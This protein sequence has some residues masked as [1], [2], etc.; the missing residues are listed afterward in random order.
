MS[1]NILF[2]SLITIWLSAGSMHMKE[3]IDLIVTD[4]TIYTVDA[5]NSKVGSMAVHH[6]KIMAVGTSESIS[7]RYQA[8]RVVD[9]KGK[10][11]YPGFVDA[12][13]HFVGYA[14]GLQY[15]D[16]FGCQ[17]FDEI[18][19]RLKKA[20]PQSSG[21]LV[22][23][24]WDQ[25]L[26]PEKN[27]PDNHR[28]NLL[29]PDIPV[30]L[31]RVDGHVVLTNQEALKRAGIGLT[32]DFNSI[33][34]ESKN[35]RLTGILSETAADRMRET[36]PAP[37][38][39]ELIDLLKIAEKQCFTVGLT[40]VS[41]AGLDY[42]QVRVIDSLQKAGALNMNVYAMLTPNAENLIKFVTKGPYQTDRLTVRSIK[43]YSDGSLG[44]RTAKLKQPYSD[45][46]SGTG[47][48]VIPPDSIRELCKM[49]YDH[50]FQVNTHCI[51]DSANKL[52][53]DI[54]G[55]FLKGKNDLR[56]RIEHAQVV[57]PEDIHFFGD[58]SVIPSVQA[59]H[60]TSDMKWA[61]ERLGP[62]RIH[63]AYAYKDLMKQ[64]GW[65]ANGT[66][67]PIENISPLLT[68]YAAVARQDVNG[69]PE[70][71]YMMNNALSRED[72]LRSIT[73]WAVKADFMEQSKGSLEAGKD[74]DFV[75]LDQ[76]I[77]HI[78]IG[79]VPEVLVLQTF[80]GGEEIFTK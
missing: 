53:L 19:E 62:V 5:N 63:G 80:I 61:G 35:G 66:D 50:G 37:S 48:I 27:F 43:I 70:G 23:R 40:M 52:I 6:G 2:L 46:P 71:G 33:E 24:G 26:W 7:A 59:T 45:A 13:C 34:V 38:G 58:Y 4:G 79:K 14:L 30:M 42:Q 78:P 55:T 73:I 75:V 41:D 54:Y 69:F 16:L 76:D 39:S 47:I 77:M 28:L 67:F 68:F 12:H 32:N 18:L 11:I 8:T 74:A 49:A 65:I 29:F 20:E 51:G 36:V 15:V 1:C 56:W 3:K 22:G 60:A 10:F 64:N 9:M 21:W 72:A 17:S 57:D 44:S 31:I 25:N